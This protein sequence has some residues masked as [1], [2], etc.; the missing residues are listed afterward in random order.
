MWRCEEW[1]IENTS[2]SGNPFDVIAEVTFAHAS[3]GTRRKTSASKKA[4]SDISIWSEWIP[5]RVRAMVKSDKVLFIS[6]APDKVP[7]VDPLAPF[8]GRGKG[9]LQAVAPDTG[10]QIM[11][12]ML[13]APP[14]F[15]GLISAN[16]SLYL[17][18]E[19][20]SVECW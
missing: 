1:S 20:G 14:V 4:E 12:V 16:G 8:E 19:N 13:E 17:S 15:D 9:I 10:K 3:T 18:L 5:V 11:E 7:D 2:W 6:G